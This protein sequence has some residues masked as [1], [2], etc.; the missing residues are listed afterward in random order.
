MLFIWPYNAHLG[1]LTQKPVAFLPTQIVNDKGTLSS[2]N[3]I[4]YFIELGIDA[5]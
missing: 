4:M 2:A 3:A 5:T 1:E